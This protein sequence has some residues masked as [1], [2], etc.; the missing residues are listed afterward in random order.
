[1]NRVIAEVRNWLV[2]SSKTKSLPGGSEVSSR[3]SKFKK[4]LPEI[5]KRLK[6]R[7]KDLTFL[8]FSETV[9]I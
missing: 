7:P 8:D 4:E 5:C 3:Y 1:M 9:E 6:R 2:A